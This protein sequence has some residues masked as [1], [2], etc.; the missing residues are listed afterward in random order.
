MNDYQLS[1]AYD[2][3]SDR[4]L[5]EYNDRNYHDDRFEERLKEEMEY[6]D[7]KAKSGDKEMLEDIGQIMCDNDLFWLAVG[8]G[9]DYTP[10]R[11]E[12]I[13]I[14]ARARIGERQ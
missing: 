10:Y 7:D 13:E 4:L 14:I 9:G 6:V 3:Y 11:Q 5:D 2:R 8:S 1:A 12:A